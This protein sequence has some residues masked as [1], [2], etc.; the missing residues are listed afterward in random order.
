MQ[1]LSRL[2]L[3]LLTVLV[4]SC[5]SSNSLTSTQ[6]EFDRYPQY[7]ILLADMREEGNFFKEY[8]HRYK[9]VYGESVGGDSLRFR[10]ALLDW[11]EV[12][13]K[14]YEKLEP[15]LGMALAS[16]TPGGEVNDVPQP[17]G[18]QY[19]GDERYGQW[20]RDNNGNSF[21]VFYGQYALM[22]DLLGYGLGGPV[23]RRDYDDYRGSN[24]S[25][26]PYFGKNN[27]YGTGGSVA[28]KTNPTFFERR[29]MRDANRRSS[30]QDRV[31]KRTR[32]SNMSNTRSRSSRG[33]GK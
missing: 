25:G 8:Y 5:G 1:Q 23:F 17:P 13:R 19:V 15:F 9:V 18:Y 33:F 30:F 14:D 27:Q 16:K 7:S 21:W 2:T 22:R 10:E 12:P 32:R 29:Q 31:S 28:K 3:L 11:Q 20:Q 24:R 6:K 26:R 4:W